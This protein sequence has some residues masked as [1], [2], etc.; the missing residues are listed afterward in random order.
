MGIVTIIT[1]VFHMRRRN[2]DTPRLFLR[3][4]INLIKRDRIAAMLFRHHFRQRRRQRRLPMIHVTY[5]PHV[6]MWLR[7]LKFLFG[8]YSFTLKT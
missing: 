5:R 2:R 6:Y 4:V 8:H 1:L 7:S 3:R